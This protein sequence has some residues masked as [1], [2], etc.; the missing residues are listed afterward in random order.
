MPLPQ[1]YAAWFEAIVGEPAPEE[2]LAT[3]SACPMCAERGFRPGVKCCTYIPPM[4]NFQAARALAAGEEAADAVRSRQ[5]TARTSSLGLL[6]TRA[7]ERLYDTHHSA[8]GRTDAVR[9]PFL[10]DRGTCSVW[11]FRDVTCATWF[12]RHQHG[13]RGK[14]LWDAAADVL[15]VA[16]GLVAAHVAGREP[17]EQIDVALGLSWEEIR[18]LPGGDVLADKEEALR[19]A[20]GRRQRVTSSHSASTRSGL[21]KEPPEVP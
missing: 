4:A 6:P 7:E 21:S 5:Q 10:S 17:Q 2:P 20:W 11:A 18:S 13:E 1:P 14:A 9:C 19:Q 16:E 15:G 3:C 8:F 12:C